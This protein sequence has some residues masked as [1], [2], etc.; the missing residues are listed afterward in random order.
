LDYHKRFTIGKKEEDFVKEIGRGFSKTVTGGRTFWFFKCPG[1]ELLL[2]KNENKNNL[3]PTGFIAFCH[4]E[5]YD[6]DVNR[7]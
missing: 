1:I 3:Q 7:W 5:I 2:I 6:S 4:R